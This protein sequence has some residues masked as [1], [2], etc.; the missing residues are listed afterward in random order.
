M[1]LTLLDV[2]YQQE[3]RDKTR[4]QL[5]ELKK[6]KVIS[7]E[8]PHTNFYFKPI[9]FDLLL[10]PSIPS[11]SK[12]SPLGFGKFIGRKPFDLRTKPSIFSSPPSSS[13]SSSS[14]PFLAKNSYVVGE[15]V[16]ATRTYDAIIAQSGII[17]PQTDVEDDDI[18]VDVIDDVVASIDPPSAAS[19]DFFRPSSTALKL[20]SCTGK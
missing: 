12:D 8:K 20:T 13:F 17:T 11:A 1:Q 10:S 7:R 9:T 3:E 14:N 6:P 15:D 16:A 2:D 5:D 19:S 4:A 18:W